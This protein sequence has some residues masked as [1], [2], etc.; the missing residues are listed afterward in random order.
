MFRK[1]VKKTFPEGT[2]IPFP[3]RFCAIM[4]LCIAF[5]VLLWV[6]SQPFMGELFEIQAEKVL[7][8]YALE[9]PFFSEL[10][11]P[12]QGFLRQRWTDLQTRLER[13]FLS[14]LAGSFTAILALPPLV[15]LW[16]LLSIILSVFLLK[17][18]EGAREAL[19]LLPFLALTYGL[20]NRMHGSVPVLSAHE[21]LFPT[22]AYLATHYLDKPLSARSLEQKAELETAWDLYL[23]KEWGGT[24]ES[25]ERGVYFFNLARVQA[26]AHPLEQK[27]QQKP[28]ALLFLFLFWSLS[29]TIVINRTNTEQISLNNS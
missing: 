16:L 11:P 21:K 27:I 25:L 13:S 28:L 19:W 5:G 26:Q 2:F 29:Y 18:R 14:K 7:V 24:E 20:D 6:A 22:E 1:R 8:K 10:T 17:K 23:Q 12:K 15:L 4:Q 9:K 3:A